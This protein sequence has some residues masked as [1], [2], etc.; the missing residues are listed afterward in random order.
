LAVLDPL[1][2]VQHFCRRDVV[3][4]ARLVVLAPFRRPPR[5]VVALGHGGCSLCLRLADRRERELAMNRAGER[6]TGD[7]GD[8]RGAEQGPAV[9][10]GAAAVLIYIIGLMRHCTLPGCGPDK[11][12]SKIVPPT[13]L[14]R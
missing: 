11:P 3:G 1:R 8:A 4:R 7:A 6:S 13:L 2:R 12:D 14:L 9:G 5:L 10:R